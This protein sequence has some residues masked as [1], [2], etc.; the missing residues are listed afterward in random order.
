VKQNCLS[1][2]I[3]EERSEERRVKRRVRKE[4]DQGKINAPRKT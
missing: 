1:H 4:K 3:Q 2:E